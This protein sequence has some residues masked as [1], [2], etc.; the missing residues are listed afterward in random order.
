MVTE[1]RT[2]AKLPRCR[3]VRPERHALPAAVRPPARAA[4]AG[5]LACALAVQTAW[6]QERTGPPLTLTTGLALS[7]TFTDNVAPASGVKESE[8][9][10][11]LAPSLQLAART[12]RLQGRVDYSLRA[13]AYAK[14]A[15]RNDVQHALNAAFQG[16]AVEQHLF[17]DASARISQQAISAFGVQTPGSSSIDPNRT[18]VRSASLSPYL[19]GRLPGGVD[20][21]ARY[22]AGTS[23]STAATAPDQDS[24]ISSLRASGGR[25]L[26]GWSASHTHAVSEFEQGRQTTQ[27]QTRLAL[28]FRPDV[29]WRLHARLGRESTDV[30]SLQ[31]Q[32]NA[33]W[34][35]GVEWTPTPR[36]AVVLQADHRYFGSAYSFNAQH[37]M[38]RTLWRLSSSR[39]ASDDRGTGTAGA[40][41]AAAYDALFQELAAIEPDPV[42]RDLLVRALLAEQGDFLTRAVSLQRRHEASMLWN[43]LRGSVS[44]RAFSGQTS[45]LDRLSGA[46]DDLSSL[47]AVR[48]HGWGFNA[49]YR[50]SPNS[51]ASLAYTRTTTTDS[52][53]QPGNDQQSASF[54]LSRQLAART[55]LSLT[56]RHTTYD[57]VQRPYD[58]NAAWLLLS[59]RF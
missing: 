36:T 24:R 32:S 57:S 2:R 44:M 48:Q 54:T 20:L 14:D 28:S 52:G 43:G 26:M 37:R 23:R 8:A 15:S 29:D 39:S 1:A 59:L 16:E 40:A 58:E 10:T 12:A 13:L 55:T 34:G 19:R 45:R 9:I 17:V 31:K 3:R 6:A 56:L 33:T 5:A 53:V 38:A 42:R 35:A 46:Q 21:E 51:S 22:S 7:Q 18:D 11:T 49:S 47:A 50:L 41:A 30:L 25:G 4:L 27:D